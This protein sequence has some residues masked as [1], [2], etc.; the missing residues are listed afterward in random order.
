MSAHSGAV[1]GMHQY[2]CRWRKHSIGGKR[3]DQ[4]RGRVLTEFF[5]KVVIRFGQV[6]ITVSV[7]LSGYSLSPTGQATE[8]DSFAVEFA[9]SRGTAM[10]F[11][12]SQDEDIAFSLLGDVYLLRSGSLSAELIRHFSGYAIDVSFSPSG[13][14]LAVVIRGDDQNGG[15]WVV[16]IAGTQL[17]RIAPGPIEHARWG[18]GSSSILVAD[19]GGK[20][21][22]YIWEHG[23]DIAT[24]D[25]VNRSA[26]AM[27]NGVSDPSNRFIYFD[28]L[29]G[30]STT[31]GVYQWDRY[32]G[33]T[34]RYVDAKTPSFDPRISANGRYLSYLRP[35]PPSDE[36][37]RGL[38]KYSA[39]VID[40]STGQEKLSIPLTDYTD[41]RFSSDSKSLYITLDGQFT[42]FDLYT[43]SRT[44]IPFEAKV[45]QKIARAERIAV[46]VA[47]DTW[48]IF[49]LRSLQGD[50]SRKY[51]LF[52]ALG[53]IWRLCRDSHSVERLTSPDSMS[54]M[55]A[56]SAKG[57]VFAH[58]EL[59]GEGRGR[60]VVTSLNEPDDP[61]VLASDGLF[62]NPVWSHDDRYIAVLYAPESRAI[63]HL[64]TGAVRWASLDVRI[65]DRHSGR[66]WVLGESIS[67]L[68]SVNR[69][70]TPLQFNKNNNRVFFSELLDPVHFGGARVLVSRSIRGN[71]KKAHLRFDG[72]IDHLLVSPDEMAAAV[73]RHSGLFVVDF[74]RPVSTQDALSLNSI[75]LKEK[76]L[77]GAAT[78]HAHWLSA[79]TLLWGAA[80]GVYEGNVST[81]EVTKVSNVDVRVSI[82][83]PKGTLVFQDVSILTMNND[84]FLPN[85]DIWLADGRITRVD[86]SGGLAAGLSGYLVNLS[87][88]TVLPGFVDAHIHAHLDLSGA[89]EMYLNTTPAYLSKLA[90]G[91]TTIFDPATSAVDPFERA[92]SVA[93]GKTLGPRIFASGTIVDPRNNHPTFSSISSSSDA[94]EIVSRIASDGS[95]AIKTY[96]QESTRVRRMIL[97]SAEDVHLATIGHAELDLSESIS[98]ILEGF[99]IIEHMIEPGWQQ[100]NLYEDVIQLV[101]QSGVHLTPTVSVSLAGSRGGP[102]YALKRQIGANPKYLRFS[103]L[104]SHSIGFGNAMFPGVS[105]YDR[106]GDE[107]YQQRV[108]E[109]V[110]MMN[111]GAKVSIGSHSVEGLDTHIEMWLIADGGAP[112]KRVLQA[113]TKVGAEKLGVANQIGT[114]EAGKLAD[115][116]VLN[117]NPLE[118]IRC[119]ADI[120]YVV[121]NGFVWHA[122]SMTQMWPE[123]KPLPKPWW[124][125]DEDWEELKPELPEP[126]ESVP[127]ADGVELEKPTIH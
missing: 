83:R 1:A 5:R 98:H 35:M 31:R 39:V 13:K 117:C 60:L 19:A 74:D 23:G 12:V 48:E 110:E 88:K 108:S 75:G 46:P 85:S 84:E 66:N 45:K 58:V 6:G 72:K 116:V 90:Y 71:S 2:R 11:D 53:A 82:A 65:F 50:V 44:T 62:L 41:H 95:I 25:L 122:D 55:P 94:D 9:V 123:Y 126:W 119:T 17:R 42:R 86:Q 51:A 125:S 81:G 57:A 21:R 114:I 10:A 113:A 20:L 18:V 7:V 76:L 107:R 32:T 87:G 43:L 109:L 102:F 92:G 106:R 104:D 15:V 69:I 80:N 100:T 115:L 105:R 61:E 111:S 101:A 28:A 54:F 30:K 64:R 79:D 34:S 124:H 67:T 112:A 29:G 78:V 118:N 89:S 52:S 56:V 127:I 27:S 14:E 120:E 49:H 59:S 37:S 73:V 91:V 121:K 103:G 99:H 16:D 68:Y 93:I 3:M 47:E 97:D 40:R 38:P 24:E 33:R 70:Y 26:P 96:G 22:R 77:Y 8:T 36:A 63:D 4:Q